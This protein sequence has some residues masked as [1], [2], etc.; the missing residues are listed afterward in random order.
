METKSFPH[1][2]Q[3][4][5][6]RPIHRATCKDFSFVHNFYF[7]LFTNNQAYRC[8]LHRILSSSTSYMQMEKASH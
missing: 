5:A 6:A 8:Y 4:L 7:F 1:A 3:H 2:N